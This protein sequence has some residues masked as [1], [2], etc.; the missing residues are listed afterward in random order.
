MNASPNPI[1]NPVFDFLRF[2]RKPDSRKLSAPLKYSLLFVG[3]IIALNILI[4][5][6]GSLVSSAI[7]QTIQFETEYAV[8]DENLFQYVAGIFVA[9]LIEESAFRLW[10]APN[11]LF[12]LISL[13]LATVQ[14]APFP[15]FLLNL[16]PLTETIDL[17]VKITF[18]FLIAGAITLFFWVRDRRGYRYADF[19][20]RYVGVYF[21]LSS[22]I[23]GLIHL[24]NY[25]KMPPLGMALLLVFPQLMGGLCFGYLRIRIGFWYAVLAHSLNNLLFTIGD[26][27]NAFIGEVGGLIWLMVLI[28][29][30]AS[31]I[32][33]ISKKKFVTLTQ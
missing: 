10:L 17:A 32:L 28:A 15:S 1:F 12:L 19:F 30:S 6:T 5:I 11:P 23:F 20:N 9:P 7:E 3:V 14:Y 33:W 29:G 13:F 24:T 21:Y 2:L 8:E 27:M 25:A 22:I 26:G 4:S 16:F 18:Y 31:I